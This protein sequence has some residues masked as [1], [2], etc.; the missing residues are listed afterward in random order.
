MILEKLQISFGGLYL[1]VW[2]CLSGL[3]DGPR[4]ESC[5]SL[6]DL[7]AANLTAFAS[8]AMDDTL[9]KER[10][11]VTLSW[12]GDL[13]IRV[14][15]C[16]PDV[17]IISVFDTFC[18]L[19]DIFLFQVLDIIFT[20]SLFNYVL[21]SNFPYKL[22]LSIF[23]IHHFS[24]FIYLVYIIVFRLPCRLIKSCLLKFLLQIANSITIS[25]RI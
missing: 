4:P 9:N 23:I 24:N 21:K 13:S 19:S 8:L 22:S 25:F 6:Y 20:L 3:G 7:N 2:L 17:G 10:S 5:A 12:L 11:V 15:T 1:L 16:N 14:A 18:S